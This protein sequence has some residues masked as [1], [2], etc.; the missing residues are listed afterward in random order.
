[1]FFQGVSEKSKTAKNQVG[2]AADAPERMT[3]R[4]SSTTGTTSS[5]KNE[6]VDALG[7]IVI[8]FGFQLLNN[9]STFSAEKATTAADEDEDESYTELNN[10]NTY[11]FNFTM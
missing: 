1:M 4:S 11:F 7:N 3:T 6:E 2:E 9:Y 10:S 8:A 5:T